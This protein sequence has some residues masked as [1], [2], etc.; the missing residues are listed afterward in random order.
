[1]LLRFLELGLGFGL[2]FGG[3]RRQ[4]AVHF[5][6]FPLTFG[7]LFG[8]FLPAFWPLLACELRASRPS[9]QSSTA[10][11]CKAT[12]RPLEGATRPETNVAAEKQKGA[13]ERRFAASS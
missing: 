12:G 1:M 9:W 7:L 8:P 13:P 4:S 11:H 3:G 6:H 2:G 10:L 5:A